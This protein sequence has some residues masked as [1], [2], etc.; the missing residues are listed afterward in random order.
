MI[1]RL[2]SVLKYANR[3]VEVFDDKVRFPNGAEGTYIRIKHPDVRGQAVVILP[4]RDG[5]VAL[6]KT[7]RYPIGEWQ[8]GLP[9]GFGHGQDPLKT[10]DNELREELGV[11]AQGWKKLG[12]VTPDSG[13]FAGKV[14]FLLAV[15]EDTELKPEDEDE[16]SEA[17]WLPVQVL[18]KKIAAQ[19]ITDG[20]TLSAVALALAQRHISGEHSSA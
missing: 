7:F 18:L 2:Q 15:I 13:M 12:E 14:A 10:A 19:E 20:F 4:I 1:E 16:V 9:R 6:V 8:W 5:E 3:Y 11:V 17:A